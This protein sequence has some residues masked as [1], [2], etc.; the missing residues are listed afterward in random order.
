VD[1]AEQRRFITLWR[2]Y[3]GDADLPIVAFFSDKKAPD[4]LAA[5]SDPCVISALPAVKE[6]KTLCLSASS[7]ICGGAKRYFGFQK[8][9]GSRNFEY[10][11][12]YGIPGKIEGE[13]YK[14]SPEIVRESQKISPSFKAPKGFI[15][16][17]RWDKLSV[18]DEP[19]IVIFLA[20]LDTISGLFAL[21]NFDEAD[22][23]GVICPFGSGCASIVYHP[24]MESKST[25]PRCVMG[26]F[27]ISARPC[28]GEES[29]SFSAPYSRFR[30]MVENMD[31]SFL[32][33]SSWK[34]LSER[35]SPLFRS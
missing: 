13:R 21:A 26:M 24:Y 27:D 15:V 14:K 12:S 30:K 11:L 8:D 25:H 23:N 3:F 19:E 29:L 31:E 2:K 1:E 18:S 33:T 7:R 9:S 20:D 10:F 5:G 32:T 17:K 34:T 16:F 28:I 22:P 4:S 35:H 6:G